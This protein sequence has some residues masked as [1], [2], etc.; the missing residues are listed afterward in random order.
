MLV[1]AVGSVLFPLTVFRFVTVT[2][3][4][5]VAMDDLTFLF[6]DLQ[7]STLM[8]ERVGDATAYDL[9]RV[10]FKVL[11]TAT[12]DHGGVIVKT[13]GDAIMARFRD[14]A[15]AVRTA[16]EMR[17]RI[18]QLARAWH[19]PARP[20]HRAPSWAGHRRQRPRPDRLLRPDRQRGLAHPG[21]CDAWRD[22]PQRRRLPRPRRGRPAARLRPRRGA[23]QA[24]RRLH[25]D[26]PSS[27]GRGPSRARG[28]GPLVASRPRGRRRPTEPPP[29]PWPQ[30]EPSTSRLKPC[31]APDELS[32]RERQLRRTLSLYEARRSAAAVPSEAAL[33]WR[34][35]PASC[36]RPS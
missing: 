9:V 34:L 4:Q 26:A 10:H 27:G 13:I 31:L 35:R 32:E 11:E 21:R 24:A 22:R 30:R 29:G 19:R 6:T 14:P 7:D 16:L 25:G 15:Q 17:E 20:A 23:S 8:Y 3:S 36:W 2:A 28:A 33:P 18:E 12:R 1:A 5:G